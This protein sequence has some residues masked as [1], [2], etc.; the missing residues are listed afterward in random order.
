MITDENRPFVRQALRVDFLTEHWEKELYAG[1]LMAADA[2]GKKV[3]EEN[4]KYRKKNRLIDK[5]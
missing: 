2:W 3:D 5:Y 4:E 1:A